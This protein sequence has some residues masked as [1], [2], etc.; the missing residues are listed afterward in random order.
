MSS[1]K[2]TWAEKL[3]AAKAKMPEAHKFYCKKSKQHFVIPAV[4]EIDAMMRGVRKG[5]VITMKQMTDHF[6]E[7]HG[8]DLCCPMTAGIFAWII[9]HAADEAEQAGAK[10]VVPWWRTLKSGGELNP[11]YPGKGDIQR[12]RLEAEGHR[13]IQKG[14]KLIVDDHIK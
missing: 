6:R 3:A 10:R 13:V 2:K 14:K 8:V 5:R 12:A 4:E 1:K 9:A 11:K 7:K